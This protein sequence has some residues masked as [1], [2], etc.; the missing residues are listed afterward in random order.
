LQL[1]PRWVY[2][3]MPNK[4]IEAIKLA[5]PAA[6]NTLLSGIQFFIQQAYEIVGLNSY[7]QGG[8]GKIERTAKGSTAKVQILKTALVP[9]LKNKNHTLSKIAEKRLAMAVVIM[10][11]EFK[12]RVLGKDKSATFVQIKLED[13]LGRYDFM[14]DNNSLKTIARQEERE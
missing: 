1:R 10:P 6:V 5:D 2:E 13:L 7:T 3:R 9:F 12:I 4:L 14:Y 8:E 11:D